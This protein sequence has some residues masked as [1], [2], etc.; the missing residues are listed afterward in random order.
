MKYAISVIIIVVWHIALFPGYASAQTAVGVTGINGFG[1]NIGYASAFREGKR[2]GFEMGLSYRYGTFSLI[3]FGVAADCSYRF[4]N[5]CVNA[6]TGGFLT[7]T[8]F[9]VE[10]GYANRSYRKDDIDTGGGY[11]GLLLII[12]SKITSILSAGMDRYTDRKENDLYIRF[13]QTFDLGN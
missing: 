3:G 4:K 6:R 10:C 8:I 13:T 1:Y 9:G 7:V 11:F 2:S 12:P 5:H